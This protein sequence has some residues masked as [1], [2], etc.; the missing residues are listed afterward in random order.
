DC[1]GGGGKGGTRARRFRS[2]GAG[3]VWSP[4]P[5]PCLLAPSPSQRPSPNAQHLVW[6]RSLPGTTLH[7]MDASFRAALRCLAEYSPGLGI[8][9]EEPAVLELSGGLASDPP[10][11]ASAE[12]IEGHAL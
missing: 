9:A 11:I 6:P 7:P 8:G 12:L 2:P 5:A 3:H 1:L 10:R 4:A